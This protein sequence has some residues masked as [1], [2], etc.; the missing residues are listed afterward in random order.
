VLGRN[1]VVLTALIA[2]DRETEKRLVGVG[3][4]EDSDIK[5]AADAILNAVGICFC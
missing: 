4:W 1:Q 3:L 2:I 5:A